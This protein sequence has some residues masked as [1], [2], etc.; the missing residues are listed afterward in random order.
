MLIH[1]R[2]LLAAF[3]PHERLSWRMLMLLV[4]QPL[5]CE[6]AFVKLSQAV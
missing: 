3:E 5:C 2:Y 4:L 6:G 1:L